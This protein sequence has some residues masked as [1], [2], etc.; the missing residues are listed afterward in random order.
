MTPLEREIREVIAS[1]GPIPVE[2]YVALC[3]AHPKH[4][5]YATRDPLGAQGDFIT[6]PEIS[7]MFG[8]L[9]G[10]WAAAVWKHI[11]SPSALRFVELGPGRG[12]L[13]AD[14]LR[15]AAVVTSFLDA[16]SVH[17]VETSPA[18]RRRQKEALGGR[19]VPVFWHGDFAEVPPGPI[20]IIANEFVDALPVHQ[21]VKMTDGWHERMVGVDG[22]D[23]LAYA[24]HEEPVRGLDG[25]LPPHV[26]AA[27]VGSLYEWRSEDLVAD[28]AQRLRRS[29]GA[30]L[31]IDYGHLHSDIGETLQAMSRHGFADPLESPGAVD[32][33]AHVDFAALVRAAQ[34]AGVGTQGPLT[35]GEFL[36]RL[37]IEE[38]AGRLKARATSGQ[39][40]D[41]DSALAR[42][43]EPGA[44]GMGELFK[45]L[46]LADPMLGSMPGF[47]TS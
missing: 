26:R 10:L 18:L 21:A 46:A 40:A 1:E 24:L 7:Q 37:G 12:T 25:L 27:P 19:G 35:Q 31:I 39:A 17:L 32:L 45:V 47:E 42:L 33:T 23:R 41:I 16:V 9:I 2:R 3:L 22:E 30:A 38:R 34:R 36:R 5:Y 43:T 4:G 44:T 14:A 20:V 6:A 8:E 13:M 11:D 29:A 15:A 28:L